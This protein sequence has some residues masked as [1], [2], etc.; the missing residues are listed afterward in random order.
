MVY[1]DSISSSDPFSSYSD[2]WVY[3]GTNTIHFQ[4]VERFV[5]IS[6]PIGYRHY[7]EEMKIRRQKFVVII[8][9]CRTRFGLRQIESIIGHYCRKE[10]N[11]D[12]FQ[13]I[14][15]HHL[16]SG[17]VPFS[18]DYARHCSLRMNHQGYVIVRYFVRDF[19]LNKYVFFSDLLGC[20]GSART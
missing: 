3:K 15:K 18:T 16:E 13:L 11:L 8:Q 2:S 5:R 4:T 9:E 20:S 7:P 17:S 19:G 10:N 6:F 12:R 1:L 14:T